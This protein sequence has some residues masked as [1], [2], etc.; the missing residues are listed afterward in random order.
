MSSQEELDRRAV[1]RLLRGYERKATELSDRG[2]PFAPVTFTDEFPDGPLTVTISA[3]NGPITIAF[4]A[5]DAE[6][7]IV[8]SLAQLRRRIADL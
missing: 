4:Y 1:L 8:M 3:E 7:T 2:E 6:A 5:P